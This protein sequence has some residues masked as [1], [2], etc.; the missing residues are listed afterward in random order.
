MKL[1]GLVLSA[2][3]TAA[4]T[5]GCTPEAQNQSLENAD[6]PTP[7]ESGD[8]SLGLLSLE[9]AINLCRTDTRDG[10][11]GSIPTYGTIMAALEQNLDFGVD[12]FWVENPTNRTDIKDPYLLALIVKNADGSRELT[13]RPANSGERGAAVCIFDTRDQGPRL[14][15]GKDGGFTYSYTKNDGTGE[16][17]VLEA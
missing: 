14:Q 12:V 16:I 15:L 3:L 8:S 2:V 7:A 6:T 5:T 4:L 11:G 9:D 13:I 1:R 10:V 17:L